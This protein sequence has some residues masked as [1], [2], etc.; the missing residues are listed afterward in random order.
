MADTKPTECA[1]AVL[2]HHSTDW[3]IG[4]PVNRELVPRDDRKGLEEC[5]ALKLVVWI[6]SCQHPAAGWEEVDIYLVTPR[7]QKALQEPEHG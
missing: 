4:V 7:G 6:D 3:K 1:I 5:K 2:K